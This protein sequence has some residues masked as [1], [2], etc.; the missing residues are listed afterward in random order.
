MLFIITSFVKSKGIS[1][2]QNE[3]F[4]DADQPLLKIIL[5]RKEEYSFIIDLFLMLNYYFDTARHDTT[6]HD[7]TRLVYWLD[8]CLYIGLDIQVYIQYCCNNMYI[9]IYIDIYGDWP[10][11]SCIANQSW[12]MISI[13]PA[14]KKL[15]MIRPCIPERNQTGPELDQNRARLYS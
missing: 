15:D 4:R 7:K 8:I 1:T 3:R 10:F 12:V 11:V 6:R 5:N 9:Y 13:P 14:A 2:G